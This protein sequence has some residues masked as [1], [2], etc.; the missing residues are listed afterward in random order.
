MGVF[1]FW[2]SGRVSEL[3]VTAWSGK[4]LTHDEND[5]RS[6]QEDV[7]NDSADRKGQ[8][9]WRA[10]FEKPESESA[11]THRS[12]SVLAQ[13]AC[14]FTSLPSCLPARM[15]ACL[16]LSVSVSASAS[17]T[18]IIWSSGSCS[19]KLKWPCS[20]AALLIA[21]VYAASTWSRVSK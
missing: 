13:S 12:V 11:R 19:P 21:R 4:K 5:P 6:N 18:P 3:T 7:E 1:F 14:L 17:A 10:G 9:D 16:S 2:T 8:D 15:P 20:A